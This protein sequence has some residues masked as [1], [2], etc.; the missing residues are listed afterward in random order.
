MPIESYVTV[1]TIG[2]VFPKDAA[3]GALWQFKFGT[4]YSGE[5]VIAKRGDCL[6][7][8]SGS[9]VVA[10]PNSKVLAL[11]GSTVLALSGARVIGIPGSIVLRK[12]LLLNRVNLS[13]S[14]E[15]S[16]TQHISGGTN[17]LPSE[18]DCPEQDEL[19][20]HFFRQ[21]RSIL[22]GFCEK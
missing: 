5:R 4:A 6:R 1:N 17:P 3:A 10:K 8:A 16:L 14:F 9:F 22:R 15:P 2:G 12:N 13:N 18:E 21:P 7:A 19:I 11:A 20:D